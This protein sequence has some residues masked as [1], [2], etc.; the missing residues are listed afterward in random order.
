[1]LDQPGEQERV[2]VPARNDERYRVI[3]WYEAR[4]KGG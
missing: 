2:D 3:A 1:V 4:E